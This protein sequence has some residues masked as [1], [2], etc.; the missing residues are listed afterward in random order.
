MAEADTSMQRPEGA[1]IAA[2]LA[3]HPGLRSVGAAAALAG[4]SRSR[5]AQVVIGHD[6]R[7]AGAREPVVA[8]ART[9][10]RMAA[11][12]GVSAQQLAGAGRGDAAQALAEIEAHRPP[13]PGPRGAATTVERAVLAAMCA[14]GVD[15]PGEQLEIL[16][17]LVADLAGQVRRLRR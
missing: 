8:N 5:W 13:A 4:L 11:A 15:S 1:L 14:Q 7:R 6:G 16:G 3:A 2:H 17:A 12:V 10:A 9:L